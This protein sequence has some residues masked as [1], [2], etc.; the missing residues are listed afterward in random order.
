MGHGTSEMGIATLR[1]H[2]L[3]EY[4]DT[5]R[6]HLIAHHAVTKQFLNCHSNRGAEHAM[7]INSNKPNSFPRY[8]YR[9]GP[10]GGTK[11]ARLIEDN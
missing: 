9:A 11:A 5:W 1:T 6:Q 10:N 7:G 2:A 4:P 3:K 8:N